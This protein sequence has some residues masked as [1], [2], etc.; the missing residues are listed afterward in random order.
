MDSRTFQYPDL[1]SKKV[2]MEYTSKGEAGL[3]PGYGRSK[4]PLVRGEMQNTCNGGD[5]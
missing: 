5:I 3:Q 1:S 2:S 4:G